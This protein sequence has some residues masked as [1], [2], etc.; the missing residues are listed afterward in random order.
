MTME[1]NRRRFLA[2]EKVRILRKHL[3]EKAPISDVC[4]EYGMTHA[5]FCPLFVPPM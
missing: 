2:E 3:V 4:D 5:V 1:E